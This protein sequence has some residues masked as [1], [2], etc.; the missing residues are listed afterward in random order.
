MLIFTKKFKG[1]GRQ[2]QDFQTS[3]EKARM[4]LHKCIEKRKDNDVIRK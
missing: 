3:I 4:L 2:I 1:V